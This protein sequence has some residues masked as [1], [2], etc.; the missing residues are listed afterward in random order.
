[1]ESQNIHIFEDVVVKIVFFLFPFQ[2]LFML[3]AG[4]RFNGTATNYFAFKVHLWIV[5]S[6]IWFIFEANF[7]CLFFSKPTKNLIYSHIEKLQPINWT[8]FLNSIFLMIISLLIY[9]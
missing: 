3:F 4:R 6:I 1:M 2:L 5:F 7:K 8:F 9:L